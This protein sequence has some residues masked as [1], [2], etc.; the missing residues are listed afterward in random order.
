MPL[1]DERSEGNIVADPPK[2]HKAC[3][4]AELTPRNL[5][6]GA[7][8]HGEVQQPLEGQGGPE[9]CLDL[10]RVV[11]AALRRDTRLQPVTNCFA[12]GEVDLVI[13]KHGPSLAAMATR[14]SV[15]TELEVDAA[16]DSHAK[17]VVLPAAGACGDESTVR[18]PL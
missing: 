14:P 12:S 1:P 13:S 5:A 6:L 4:K 2:V 9:R 15:G 8:H 10:V 16:S 7:D 11:D 17:V 18:V 3:S